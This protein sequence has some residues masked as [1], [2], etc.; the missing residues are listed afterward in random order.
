MVLLNDERIAKIHCTDNREKI[1]SLRQ[2]HKNIIIDETRRQISVN[3]IYFVMP[4]NQLL[5]N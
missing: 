2:I 3:Q 4:E 5:K 1:L